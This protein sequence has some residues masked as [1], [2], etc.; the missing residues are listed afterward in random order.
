MKKFSLYILL[1]AFLLPSCKKYL[2]V[3]ENPN[4][5][6]TAPINGLLGQATYQSALD[7]YR[8]GYLTANYVQYFASSNPGS[9]SDI[10]EEIDASGTWTSLYN[11]MTD[12]YDLQQLGANSGSS[13]HEGVA[14]IL[15]ALNLKL[16][17]DIW[18]DA[19]FTQAFTSVTITPSFDDAQSLYAKCLSLLSEGI[20]LLQQPSSAFN[21]DPALDFIHHGSKAAWIKTAYAL[22]A[23]FLSLVSKTAS[24]NADNVLSALNSAYTSNS[25]DAQ[26]TTFSSRNPWAQVALNNAALLLDG[27]LST[28][29]VDMMD[30]TI[31]GNFDPRLPLIAS[32]TQYNDYRGTPNGVGRIGTGIDDEESYLKVNGY[33]SSTN[34]PLIIMSYAEAKFLEAE[35]KFRKGTDM[36]GAYNAYLDGI[37]ANMNKMG[38][39][40]GDRDTYVNNAV[41]S[42]GSANLT[43]K[44]IF[45]EKY[46]A[47]FLSSETWNDARRTNYNYTGFSLP[48]NAV[49][50]TFIRRLGYPSVELSRNGSNVPAFLGLDQKYWWD[51]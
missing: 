24:Y 10:Y 28:Q 49:L 18:G 15:M 25:D 42:V 32:L 14:K 40:S 12:I 34:S 23:R 2:D 1:A 26:I 17:H 50:S 43:L 51:Q 16:V 46:K 19:P 47:L 11:T 27:F 3:N 30:G 35:A 22:K 31:Y 38:V 4:Q 41:V 21:L 8:I 13:E 6:T 29:F 33:Y 20:A 37:R 9:S 5:P 48:T 36:V 45:K 7:V 44:L 39:S